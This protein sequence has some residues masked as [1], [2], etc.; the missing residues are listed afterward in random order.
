MAKAEVPINQA[1]LAWAMEQSGV[2]EV[3]LAM[4]CKT[5]PEAVLEWLTGEVFPGK[6]EFRRLVRKLRR[7]GAI[8][9]LPAPPGGDPAIAA[10]RAPPGAEADRALI[11][12]EQTYIHTAERI[13]KVAGWTRERTGLP[14][15]PWPRL[16]GTDPAP[17]AERVRSFLGWDLK[18]QLEE[19]SASRVSA[20]LR[21]RI[22]D[23]GA[24]VLQLPLSQQGCR[25]F[26]LVDEVAPV[27]AVNSAYTVPA[28]IFSM[29]HEV[30][31]LVLHEPGFC[32]RLA[33]ANATERWC[34]R[35][36][37]VLLMP[38]KAFREYVAERF[39][40]SPVAD[41]EDVKSVANK[42]SVSLRAAAFRVEQ[43]GLGIEGLYDEVDAKAD[44]KGGGG[45]SDDPTTPGVRLREWGEGYVRTVVAAEEGQLFSRADALEYLNV[46]GKQYK[47]IVAR[48]DASDA[49][50]DG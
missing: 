35:F 6:T 5:S 47:E 13:R 43:L 9:F 46:S 12:R 34:E 10:F 2:D 29:V 38:E 31:H 7:P 27:V 37:A 26:S 40:G 4:A 39:A 33:D 14:P 17:A 24:L 21:Q 22:E 20:E 23:R 8:Y 50:A 19:R 25:G 1:V 3:D 16:G 49:A 41:L 11:D 30:G 32:A 15:K 44:F 28:R 42:F 45:F 36:A 18:S 48:L